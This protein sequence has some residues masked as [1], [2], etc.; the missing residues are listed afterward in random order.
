MENFNYKKKY[1]QNFLIDNY[2]KE[3]IVESIKPTND[4]LIIE[5]GP[6]TG[7]LTKFLKR[8]NANLI[9]VE[10]DTDTKIYLEKLKDEK[11]NFVF[12]DF[13]KMDFNDLVKNINYNNIYFVGNLPYYITTPIIERIINISPNKKTILIMIQKEVAERFLAKPGSKKYGYITVLLNYYFNITKVV[14][15]KKESFYPQPKVDSS[16]V[17]MV[18]KNTIPEVDIQKFKQFLKDAFKFKRKTLKNN[19]SKY[20]LEEINKILLMNDYSLNN[21]AEDI[22]LDT[23][24]DL[25]KIL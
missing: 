25:Y 14:D 15:V 23:F 13:L 4:D 20:N 8:Y 1:G 21:R 5:I 6:G 18:S 10:V 12:I 17:K 19:L 9:G 16:V 11:T 24:L 22:D 2:I 3:K 7:A